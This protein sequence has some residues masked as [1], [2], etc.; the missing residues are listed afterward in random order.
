LE[1]FNT[2][3][4]LVDFKGASFL[5]AVLVLDASVPLLVVR[6]FALDGGSAACWMILP[7]C[8]KQQQQEDEETRM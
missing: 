4:S 8:E 5:C 3:G 1:D 6:V 2:V 7:A